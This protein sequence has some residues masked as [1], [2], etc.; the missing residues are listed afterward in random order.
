[1]IQCSF[2]NQYWVLHWLACQ[3]QTLK[4]RLLPRTRSLL[5]FV[6]FATF[7]KLQIS[8][9]ISLATSQDIDGLDT[10][11]GY[12]DFAENI[13]YNFLESVFHQFGDLNYN[14]FVSSFNAL[15]VGM[16]NTL[17]EQFRVYKR[18]CFLQGK[19]RKFGKQ[20]SVG[21]VLNILF[22]E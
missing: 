5:E 16:K 8:L 9:L 14:N 19:C 12:E 3:N 18:E 10:D 6:Y 20:R 4:M 21:S 1:M 17:E 7:W 2:S 11:T 13:P 22:R 15:D